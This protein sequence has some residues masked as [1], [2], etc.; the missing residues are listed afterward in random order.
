ME[1]NYINIHSSEVEDIF[2][3]IPK[4]ITRWGMTLIFSVLLF[5]LL[6][7]NF[8]VFPDV[9]HAKSTIIQDNNKFKVNIYVRQYEIH[10]IPSRA[11]FILK[12]DSYPSQKYGVYKSNLHITGNA[13][14]QN[15]YFVLRE[16]VSPRLKTTMNNEVIMENGLKADCD[17]IISNISLFRKLINYICK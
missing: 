3:K 13:P 11:T 17:I 5:V 14:I 2:T 12:F 8:I 4:W 10:K 1:N 7:S 6:V 9:V 15:D 16:D